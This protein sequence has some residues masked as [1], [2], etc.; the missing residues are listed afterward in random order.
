MAPVSAIL[1]SILP[2]LTSAVTAPVAERIN[3]PVQ[4]R[5]TKIVGTLGPASVP[6]IRELIIA[7]VNVFRLNFSH[8][9]DPNTQTPIVNE[10]RKQSKDLKIPVG[11]L[12]DL[13]GP[14]IRCNDF[15]PNPTIELK[16]GGKVRL[17]VSDG[18]G[19][20]GVIT[21]KIPEVV[22]QLEPGHRVLL[23]DGNL[24][25]KVARRISEIEIECDILVGGILKSHKGV[26]VPDIRLD[27]PALTEKDKRD[28]AFAFKMRLDYV[29]MSFVQRPEDVVELQDMFKKLKAEDANLSTGG[30]GYTYTLENGAGEIDELEELWRPHIILK[31]EKPQALD[32]IDE[33]IRVGDG[34]MVARGDMGVEISLPRVPVIQKMLIRKTNMAGKPVITAT[35]MLESMIN[36]PVPTRAEVSDVANAVF[37]GTDAVMLSAECATGNFP[38]E[39][40]QMMSSVCERAEAGDIYMHPQ[41][42]PSLE[43]ATPE[44]SA[45]ANPIADATVAA[46]EE[47]RAASIIVFTT[48]GDMPIYVSKRRP[49]R[50]VIAVTSSLS[51]FSRLALVYAVYPIL[52]PVLSHKP[53]PLRPALSTKELPTEAE[54]SPTA[55]DGVAL[56]PVAAP[57][58]MGG[59]SVV[60]PTVLSKTSVTFQVLNTDQIYARAERDILQA[61]SVQKL[62]LDQGDAVVFCA[63]FH[64][65]WP[66]LSC[67]LKIGRFGDAIKSARARGYWDGALS[68]L[69]AE[70]HNHQQ[71]HPVQDGHA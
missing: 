24:S 6:K 67:T 48:R 64:S 34:I 5:R 8:V 3:P 49:K 17:V 40:V 1:N 7:G 15:T 20:D 47:A 70:R 39:T 62:G 36:S 31:I 56:T 46:A 55:G 65:P 57:P 38:I 71:Q 44:F 63:G 51:L 52:T 16:T 26:N 9:Q 11:I 58:V 68:H 21:T 50:P 25:I 23:D 37:D 14:K 53:H 33:L 27:V 30:R 13:G 61:V 66:G 41:V 2:T 12:G 10:I 19:T 69:K 59:S 29:A 18:P 43:R 28:A 22:R 32:V 54:H 4:K 35:Q 42:I 60:A 45:F